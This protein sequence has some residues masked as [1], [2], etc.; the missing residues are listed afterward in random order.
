MNDVAI[1]RGSQFLT[2]FCAHPVHTNSIIDEF[3]QKNVNC[4]IIVI[5]H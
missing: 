5:Q 4:L 1:D 3:N 2:A